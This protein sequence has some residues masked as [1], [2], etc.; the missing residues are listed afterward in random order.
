MNVPIFQITAWKVAVPLM[1]EWMSSPEFGRHSSGKART[2]LQIRDPDGFEGW[3]EAAGDQIAGIEKTHGRILHGSA[4]DRCL[5][6]LDLWEEGETYWSRPAVPSTFAPDP[7][8]LRHRLR[9]PLQ[10]LWE[11]ALTDLQA[12]RAG[13]SVGQFFGGRWRN[14][15]PTDYWSGR[16]TP[17]QAARAARRGREL[18]FKGIKLKTTLEDPN[19]ERLEAIRDAVGDDFH[20]TVDPNGRFYRFDD[21][22]K[23]IRAMDRVG[24]LGILE[25][26]FPRFYLSEFSALRGK[27]DARLVVHLDPEESFWSVLESGVAGGLNIDSHRIGPFQWRM[28]AGAAEQ[29]N[30]LV[31]HGGGA[32][33]GIGTAW[34]LQLAACAPN[35][36]LPGDQSGPWLRE[37]TLVKQPF[38]VCDGAVVVPDG[39]GTGVDIDPDALD[40]YTQQKK[41]W[42]AK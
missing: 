22:W 28:L 21:A 9:H 2:L 20:V 5:S 26:P 36:R 25:D 13:M 1:E 11:Y 7:A 16:V 6:H 18:G 41:V 33:L 14:A 29:A 38:R 19:V 34:E 30:L 35:C 12:R 4:G 42:S 15:V 23:T 3:G 31:W 39:P 24:N 8:N 37:N 10:T 27:I 32:S 40:R 17:E